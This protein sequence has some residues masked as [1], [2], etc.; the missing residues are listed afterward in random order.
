MHN[1]VDAACKKYA[2]CDSSRNIR[3]HDH[4]IAWT[5]ADINHICVDVDLKFHGAAWSFETGICCHFTDCALRGVTSDSASKQ[6]SARTDGHLARGVYRKV[7]RITGVLSFHAVLIDVKISTKITY[8]CSRA[9]SGI[10][11]IRKFVE[12]VSDGLCVLRRRRRSIYSRCSNR[13]S[14]G[15]IILA[16]IK[17]K[18][19]SAIRE[20]KYG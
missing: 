1:G 5:I 11:Q 20:I 13:I 15:C 9:Y 10:A 2:L 3:C 12:V 17:K 19:S 18:W 7:T 8:T 16:K 6:L 14:V 4:S